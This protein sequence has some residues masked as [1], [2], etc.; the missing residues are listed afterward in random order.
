MA[1]WKLFFC[2]IP[3]TAGTSLRRAL[4][5]LVRPSQTVPDLRSIGHNDGRYPP[6]SVAMAML[7]ERAEKTR[8]FRGHYHF[9]CRH[10]LPEGFRTAVVLRE[11]VERNISLFRHMIAHHGKSHDSLLERLY[12]G[13][14]IG[15]G[16]EMTRFLAGSL[17]RQDDGTLSD[18]HLFGARVEDSRLDEA[19]AALDVCD[20]VGLT[21]N[22]PL[23]Q[24]QLS[25]LTRTELV[26]GIHNESEGPAPQFTPQE[27]DLIRRHNEIDQKLYDFAKAKIK[28]ASIG[29]EKV[30][31]Q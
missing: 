18:R 11:P 10:H 15:P 14:P 16:N 24:E 13:L 17:I 12:A 2:H 25:E 22:M 8:L 23:I 19:K 5:A 6:L 9:A 29:A 3:K 21:S 7:E 26:V 4:E 31:R 28:S 1:R 27:I 30:S 20:Y